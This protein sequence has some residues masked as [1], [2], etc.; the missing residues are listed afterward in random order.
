MLGHTIETFSRN[1]SST[2]GDGGRFSVAMTIALEAEVGRS[3]SDEN[4]IAGR[5]CHAHL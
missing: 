1:E 2:S 5:A 3:I 4:L